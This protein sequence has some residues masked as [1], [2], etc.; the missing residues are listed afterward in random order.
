MNSLEV[1]GMDCLCLMFELA[2]SVIQ[3][4]YITIDGEY[5]SHVRFADDIPISANTQ[6][7]LQQMLQELAGESDNQG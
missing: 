4:T 3:K 2:L 5:L 1:L 7:E 6:K